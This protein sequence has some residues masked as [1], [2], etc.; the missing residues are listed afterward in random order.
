MR[1]FGLFLGIVF[2]V[3]SF[4]GSTFA[5]SWTWGRT[6]TGKLDQGHT[7]A[8]DSA[9]NV[10]GGGFVVGPG[11][12]FFGPYSVVSA[13]TNPNFSNAE[14]TKYSSTGVPQWA[15]GT[16]NGNACLLSVTTDRDGSLI[17]FGSY[18][19]PS[20][21]IGGIVLPN[22]YGSA[23]TF[24][25]DTNAR[26]FL[27]KY[28]SAGVLQWAVPGGNCHFGSFAPGGPARPYGARSAATDDAGNIY[29]TS[30]FQRAT[31]TIGT[32][33]LANA[34]PSGNTEDIFIA[35]YS[36]AGTVLWATSVGGVRNDHTLAIDV[37]P[38]GEVYL[39]GFF[40]SPTLPIGST[41]LTNPSG[42]DQPFLARFSTALTP[43]WSM[44]CAGSSGASHGISLAHDAAGNIYMAGTY[45]DSAITLGSVTLGRAFP[46]TIWTPYG[47][48]ALFLVKVT[49]ANTVAWGQQIGSPRSYVLGYGVATRC[50][51][52][53]V[54]GSFSDTI[55]VDGHLFMPPPM[56]GT[57]SPALLLASYD[58][59]GNFDAFTN[60]NRYSGGADM[61]ADI[62]C[63]RNGNL[64][65]CG[66]YTNTMSVGP[67]LLS[68]PGQHHFFLGKFGN[69][70]PDT[71]T[72]STDTTICSND[73]I[74]LTAPAGYGT[75]LWDNATTVPVR[76]VTASGTYWVA[77]SGGICANELRMDTFRVAVGVPD[78][79]A[80]AT[81][82]AACAAAT[83]LVLAGEPGY[84]TYLWSEGSTSAT[85]GVSA[86]ATYVVTAQLGCSIVADTF[87]VTIHE[88]PVVEIDRM[89]AP[90]N[91][92]RLK[93]NA[94]PGVAFLWNDGTTA[95]SLNVYRSG[96]Y[97]VVVT[98]LNGCT[99]QDTAEVTVSN[100][101]R[102]F[103][104]GITQSHVIKYGASTQLNADSGLIYTWAPNDGS[105]DNPN[106][107]NP[108][109]TPLKPTTYLVRAYDR[110]GCADTA[111]VHI[112]V[113]GGDVLI[114]GAFTPNGDGL[115][116]VFRVVHGGYH[117][118]VDVKVFNRW[119][120]AVYAGGG[121]GWD[122]THQ[123]V[124]QPLGTYY[125]LV[126]L[127]EPGG[128]H[129]IYKGDLTLI[130]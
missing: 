88:G 115:N 53:W 100:G 82:T 63:D 86:S 64:L 61:E 28:N 30:S 79:L 73:G 57:H 36:P 11:T 51:K 32:Y 113:V 46:F 37:L 89:R 21:T 58:L 22:P 10:F 116:D 66:G 121:T 125:Y 13:A 99:A 6:S 94:T 7:V 76:T 48:N 54:C 42:L 130:R 16:T 15:Y 75:Y 91:Q 12:V 44:T 60:L 126:E 38:S 27:A 52:V 102:R 39:A 47:H 62:A 18:S 74:L 65:I 25:T 26:Y 56:P 45:S 90:C 17:V 20:I 31:T 43:S 2:C 108:V 24:F 103:L 95:D 92:A 71:T 114:P 127:A 34:D 104:A 8:T 128:A 40:F 123:G 120:E 59:S 112:D 78:T 50:N 84:T 1:F 55:D 80:R 4:P 107:N 19:T 35:K 67:D 72:A 69:F 111:S 3:F 93:A 87:H 83:P 117:K 77:S 81:D 106:I 49:P 105:L 129:V 23:T 98:D 124:A 14:W 70:L 9:G 97:Q 122:G 29:I 101:T 41:T 68:H 119:G 85:I 96:S 118:V 110:D 33:T 109:A 5:Q